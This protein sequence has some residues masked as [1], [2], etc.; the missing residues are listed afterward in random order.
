LAHDTSKVLRIAVA[1]LDVDD[2][3]L[4]SVL[5]GEGEHVGI[6]VDTDRQPARPGQPGKLQRDVPA[7]A[8]DVEADAARRN[9]D[10]FE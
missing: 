4:G 3:V 7:A 9:A 6:E 8:A 10:P 1:E 2:A 5:L